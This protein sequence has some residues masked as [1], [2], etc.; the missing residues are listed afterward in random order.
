MDQDNLAR[1]VEQ[2]S[3][4]FSLPVKHVMAVATL[5]SEDATIPFIARY[6]KE[7]TGSMDEVMISKIRDRLEQLNELD[8]RRETIISSIEKQEKLTP[9]LMQKGRP[10]RK[11]KALSPW[12]KKFLI[13]TVSTSTK[14]LQHLLIPRKV[15][16]TPRRLWMERATSSANGSTK[17]RKPVKTF[18]N[19]SG[20]KV[21]SNPS[22]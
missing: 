6:R 9:E 7:L 21:L 4:G 10:L 3:K 11:K 19:Y 20:T 12:Q 5:L 8:Q 18:A 14:L 2:I 22:S 15:S 1:W 16:R 17:I 13:R